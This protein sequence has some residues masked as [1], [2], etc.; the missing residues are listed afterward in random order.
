[1]PIDP[2]QPRPIAQMKAGDRIGGKAFVRL[3]VQ[4]IMRGK[5]H[6]E[7]ADRLV[8][9]GVDPVRFVQEVQP[10]PLDIVDQIALRIGA[11]ARQPAR[12]L[13]HGR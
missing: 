11:R 12:K 2:L 3:D 10:L 5:A 8:A 6:E 7:R 4:K 9:V 13:R 1:M